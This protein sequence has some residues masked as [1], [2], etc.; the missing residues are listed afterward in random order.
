MARLSLVSGVRSSWETSRNNCR[1]ESTSVSMRPAMSSKSRASCLYSGGREGKVEASARA[2]RSPDANLRAVCW[3][4]DTGVER[5]QASHAQNNPATTTVT[6]IRPV[7]IH[8]FL[9]GTSATL[10]LG[11]RTMTPA[12]WSLCSTVER[13]TS[14]S[15][16]FPAASRIERPIHTPP[17]VEM[18]PNANNEMNM[19]LRIFPHD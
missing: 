5:R 19:N 15:Y 14:D 11:T 6:T 18:M 17:M 13:T 1:W 2:F 7:H 10:R 12:D 3:R 9:T 4:R 16:W 8:T